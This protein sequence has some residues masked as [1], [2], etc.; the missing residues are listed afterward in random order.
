MSASCSA[1]ENYSRFLQSKYFE[2]F[3]DYRQKLSHEFRDASHD[4][5]EFCR[6]HCLLEV[7]HYLKEF[8]H[9]I[10]RLGDYLPLRNKFPETWDIMATG[11]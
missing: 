10:L 3:N 4:C 9:C 8:C 6:C 1:S 7:S 5:E 2:V 11:L